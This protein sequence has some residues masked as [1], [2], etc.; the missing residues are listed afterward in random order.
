MMNDYYKCLVE[1]DEVL[2][3][4]N[5]EE[6]NKIPVEIRRAITDNKDKEYN[7]KYDYTKNLKEQNL[8]RESIA[9]LSYIN[10]EYLLD[11]EQKKLMEQ[12]HVFNEIKAEEEKLKKYN[13]DNILKKEQNLNNENMEEIKKINQDKKDTSL[14]QKNNQKWYDKVISFLKKLLKNKV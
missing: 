8:K 2:K 10:M 14:V 4:L 1:V 5:E 12:L 13:I 11:D 3:Y 7:W 9:M 6:L